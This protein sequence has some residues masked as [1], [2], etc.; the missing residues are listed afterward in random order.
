MFAIGEGY[1]GLPLLHS[2]VLVLVPMPMVGWRQQV[3]IR[4]YGLEVPRSM[5][6]LDLQHA[7]ALRRRD[8]FRTAYAVVLDQLM[9]GGD[10][11]AADV[12]ASVHA[13]VT[14]LRET[15]RCR[16]KRDRERR[17]KSVNLDA[18]YTLKIIAIWCSPQLGWR[19]PHFSA[20]LAAVSRTTNPEAI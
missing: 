4:R 1:C 17:D 8:P 3:L 11:R 6:S 18:S 14:I 9:L 2:K 7:F 15:E 10:I 20:A 5:S 13:E 12:E 19:L 16:R